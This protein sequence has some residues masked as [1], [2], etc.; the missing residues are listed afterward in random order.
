MQRVADDRLRRGPE[1]PAPRRRRAGQ[2]DPRHREH[3][4]RHQAHRQPAALRP[5]L[6]LQLH[7]GTSLH[8]RRSHRRV[9]GRPDDYEHVRGDLVERPCG[10]QLAERGRVHAEHPRDDS[11]RPEH[12][13]R[14]LRARVRRQG[15]LP[16]R[17]QHARPDRGGDGLPG[18]PERRQLRQRA[19]LLGPA[20]GLAP[21]L[22]D[23]R[24][25][26]RV[27]RKR[28]Q[29][30]G[31]DVHEPAE[32]GQHALHGQRRRCL[33]DGRMRR[34]RNVRPAP[35]GVRHHHDDDHHHHDHGSDD[36]DHGSDHHHHGGSYHHHHLY[37]GGDD[38]HLYR[39]HHFDHG[40][41]DHHHLYHH[42]DE[43]AFRLSDPG[44]L[45]DACGPREGRPEPHSARHR[46]R[47]RLHHHLRGEDPE[48]QPG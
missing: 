40:D 8:R 43:W 11:R 44:I 26:Q 29:P 33:H 25:Q 38:H 21:A 7:A 15:P 46:R 6:R 39:R 32:T 36:H 19:H 35:H 42:P 20:V 17:R 41:H 2:T 30:A 45:G 37:H 5:R 22:P 1:L 3:P 24:R 47:R 23:L 13:A 34:Q 27:Y 28:V 12:P 31:W 48:H 14:L 4:G 9:R 16:E 18:V 10:G